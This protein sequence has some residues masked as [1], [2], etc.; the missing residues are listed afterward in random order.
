[1]SSFENLRIVD[2]FYQTS[3]YFPMPTVVVSTL[4]GDGTTTLGPYSLVQ[5]YYIAGQ[6]YYAM[7]LNCTNSSNTA[8]NILRNGKCAL[9]FVKDD[10]KTFKEM[11]RLGF[12]GKTPAEKMKDCHFELI[13][14]EAEGERPLILKNDTLEDGYKSKEHIGELEGVKP[15]YNNFNGITS[16]YGC[17]FI[18]KMD[19][20]LMEEKYAIG[21]KNGLTKKSFPAVPVDYGYHDSKNFWYKRFRSIFPTSEPIATS[22]AGSVDSVMYCA[23][24]LDTKVTF[25][26]E[27]CELYTKIP[28][29]FMKAALLE[30]AQIAEENGISVIDKEHGE[31]FCGN[32]FGNGLDCW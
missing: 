10:R 12:P 5:P 26:K 8:Q 7:L 14:G 1:M 24:R 18:L 28:R 23:E 29:P 15:P 3:L 16:Q 22:N 25:T 20:V 11:V 21:L 19:K 30:V 31:V 9:N 4:C 32:A 6:D 2:N 13:K 27:A 17:H